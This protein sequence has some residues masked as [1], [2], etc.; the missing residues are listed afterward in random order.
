[1]TQLGI[2]FIYM[3]WMAFIIALSFFAVEFGLFVRPE[4]RVTTMNG[5]WPSQPG[6]EDSNR[7]RLASFKA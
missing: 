5:A 2:S 4:V 1:M 7:Y 3:F 6:N